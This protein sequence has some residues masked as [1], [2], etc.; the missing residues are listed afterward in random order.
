MKPTNAGLLLLCFLAACAGPDKAGAPGPAATA[1]AEIKTPIT[2]ST[3]KAVPVNRTQPLANLGDTYVRI[4]GQSPLVPAFEV[5]PGESNPLKTAARNLANY[6]W[7]K[8]TTLLI[9]AQPINVPNATPPKQQLLYAA[10]EGGADTVDLHNVILSPYFDAD[11]GVAIKLESAQATDVDSKVIQ[12][13][14]GALTLAAT[15]GA[16]GGILAPL[17]ASDYSKQAAKLDTAVEAFLKTSQRQPQQFPFDPL[18]MERIDLVVQAGQGSSEV[19]MSLKYEQIESLIGK[20]RREGIPRDPVDI[21]KTTV[22]FVEPPTTIH[23]A[24]AQDTQL[25]T[26]YGTDTAD[27]LQKFC[28]DLPNKL[29]AMGLKHF[30]RLA[31]AYAYL[32]DSSWNSKLAYRVPGDSCSKLI[33]QLPDIAQLKLNSTTELAREAADQR[34]LLVTKYRDSVWKD[35]PAAFQNNSSEGWQ[36]LLAEEVSVSATGAAVTLKSGL[37]IAVGEGSTYLRQDVA[38]TLASSLLSYKKEA[39]SCFSLSNETTGRYFRSPCVSV[40]VNGQAQPLDVEFTVADA[41]VPQEKS[42]PLITAIRF[43]SR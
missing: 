2:K 39:I 31:V 10:R 17:V 14:V 7:D 42:Y 26:A 34:T 13:A 28:R 6:L 19:L 38:D 40:D 9:V 16:G 25:N 3:I 11:S 35:I 21:N 43:I 33:Q 15:L 12:T 4:V 29:A 36:K 1:A 27:S 18:T 24:V 20:G 23:S 22:S 32:K 41:Y 37:K 5:K 8:R 30:D